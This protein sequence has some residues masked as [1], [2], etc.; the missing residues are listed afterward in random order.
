VRAALEQLSFNQGHDVTIRITRQ[1]AS[2]KSKLSFAQFNYARR[3]KTKT[4]PG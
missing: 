4:L 1:D 3:D 2:P